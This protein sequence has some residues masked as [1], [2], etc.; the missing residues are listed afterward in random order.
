MF[1]ESKISPWKAYWNERRA[2]RLDVGGRTQFN[3]SLI[4]ALEV[5]NMAEI[6]ILIVK[7][8]IARM[9]SRRAH[10]REDFPEKMTRFGK[11][12]SPWGQAKPDPLKDSDNFMLWIKLFCGKFPHF[13]MEEKI[14]RII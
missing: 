3:T 1:Y 14:V 5:I 13:F 6:C 12:A 10:F 9:E 8:A 11:R 2:K 4:T 7:S